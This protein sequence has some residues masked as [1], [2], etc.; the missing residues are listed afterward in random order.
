MPIVLKSGCLN[1]IET[2][3]SVQGR[4]GIDFPLNLPTVE[5]GH[6]PEH[7]EKII[8]KYCTVGLQVF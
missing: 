6:T 7:H 3:G 8:I 2:P 5:V 4:E 1:F